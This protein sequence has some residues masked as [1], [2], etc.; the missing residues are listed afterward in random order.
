M[1]YAMTGLTVWVKPSKSPTNWT[2]RRYYKNRAFIKQRARIKNEPIKAKEEASA[3]N[4]K[5]PG[6]T[7]RKPRFPL[8]PRR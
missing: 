3:P 2:N 5:T 8:H 4:P 1:S 6:R 7:R